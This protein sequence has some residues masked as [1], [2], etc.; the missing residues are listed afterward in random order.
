MSDCSTEAMKMKEPPKTCGNCVNEC[1]HADKNTRTQ[2]CIHYIPDYDTLEQRYQQL[3]QVARGLY[4][5][6]FAWRAIDLLNEGFEDV[7]RIVDCELK[8]YS[9]QLEALG[10]NLDD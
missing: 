9:E 6:A 4:F 1:I 10:V 3:S 7:D 8:P 5:Q 2:W